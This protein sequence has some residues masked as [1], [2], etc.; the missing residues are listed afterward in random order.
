MKARLVNRLPTSPRNP[1]PAA[2]TRRV[3]G[4]KNAIAITVAS[5]ATVMREKIAR[6]PKAMSSRPPVSGDS[7][8]ATIITAITRLI[9]AL[10]WSRA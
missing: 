7:I 4:R 9:F 1:T 6:Q 5:E 3:S 8:W 10:I 2:R